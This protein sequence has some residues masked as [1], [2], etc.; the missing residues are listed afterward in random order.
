MQAV[1]CSCH[2]KNDRSS[3]HPPLLDCFPQQLHYILIL[4]TTAFEALGPLNQSGFREALLPTGKA[5]CKAQGKLLVL[6]FVLVHKFGQAVGY[7]FKQLQEN[8]AKISTTASSSREK[9]YTSDNS[10]MTPYKFVLVP[11]QWLL[12]NAQLSSCKQAWGTQSGEFSLVHR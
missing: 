11:L 5:E 4:N 7:V 6:D 10:V 8:C 12:N 3:T 2:V 9:S 1:R